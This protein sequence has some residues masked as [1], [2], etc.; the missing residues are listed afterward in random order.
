[1]ESKVQPSQRA[2]FLLALLIGR[3]PAYTLIRIVVLAAAVG[4]TYRFV[5]V[6]VQ[7][8]GPSMLPTYQESGV[9]FVNRLAYMSHE[10][11][12]GD[13]VTIRFSGT[14]VM[15]MKRV[16]GLPGETVAFHEGYV[17]INGTKLDEPYV[18]YPTDWEL[19]PVIVA[20]GK[21]FVVGDNR[22]MPPESHVFGATERQRIIG[23][24]ILCKN[25][26]ASSVSP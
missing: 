18:Q 14:S 4:L 13:V 21:Y 16:I 2:A 26:F 22:S 1:M 23:K 25:L 11:Q 9:N 8:K 3:R 10:P 15:L 6:P 12:R 19:P 7:V 17:L 5:L 24:I 20:P